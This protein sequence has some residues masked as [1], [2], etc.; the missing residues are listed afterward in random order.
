M[1]AM[2]TDSR[3]TTHDLTIENALMMTVGFA[4]KGVFDPKEHPDLLDII[5]SNHKAIDKVHAFAERFHAGDDA[6]ALLETPER[7]TEWPPYLVTRSPAESTTLPQAF[8]ITFEKARWF[9]VSRENARTVGSDEAFFRQLAA[10]EMV[11][12][13]FVQN[14][15]ALEELDVAPRNPKSPRPR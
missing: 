5:E 9:T 7:R 14:R 13:F 12:E 1:S 4:R 2:F 11:E 3:N 10:I 8:R 6:C 15:D